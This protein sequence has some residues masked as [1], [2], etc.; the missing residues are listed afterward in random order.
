MIDPYDFTEKQSEL[1][2]EF[3][4]YVLDHPEIDDSLPEDAYIYFE[5][6]GIFILLEIYLA[7]IEFRCRILR[8]LL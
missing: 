4:K 6:Y 2:A 5:V 1:A 8:W 7:D 3:S